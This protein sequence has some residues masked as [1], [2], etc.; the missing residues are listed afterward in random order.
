M[1]VVLHRRPHPAVVVGVLALVAALAGTAVAGP[2][3]NT[4]AVSKKKVKKIAKKQAKKQIKKLAPGLSVAHAE[5]ADSAG[6][7]DSAGTA[8]SFGGM[9]ARRFAPFTLGGGGSRV[10]GSFGPFSLRAIC[11]INQGGNDIARVVITTSQ[12][13]SAFKG[14]GSANDFDVGEFIAYVEAGPVATGT[15]ELEED[16]GVAIAPD[17][18]EL[19][20]H[21]LYAGVNVLGQPGRCRFGGVIFQT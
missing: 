14:E 8:D 5:T 4:S 17:G 15:R 21:Q 13:N 2:T 10:L 7:T 11:T 19:L 3:A 20:G 18:T 1:R 12:N 9:T 16:G 6:T